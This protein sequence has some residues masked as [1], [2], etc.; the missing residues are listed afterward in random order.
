MG[1]Y[2]QD[3]H[4]H[5]G[6][7]ADSD[8]QMETV[9]KA[10]ILKGIDEIAFTDHLDFGPEDVGGPFPLGDYM[11]AIHRCR[12]RFGRELEIRAGIEVGEPHIYANE[13]AAVLS[14]GDFDLVLGSAHYAANMEPAWHEGF[15]KE[16]LSDAYASY[17][18]QVAGLAAEG[19]FDVLAHLDLVK[20]D[21]RRFGKVYD[22]PGPYAGLI[23]PALSTVIERG[24]GIELNT[25]PWRRG[26]SE[27]CPSLEILRWYREMGGEILILGSDAHVPQAVGSHFGPALEMV[28]AAGFRRLA[29]FKRRQIDWKE[30]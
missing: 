19:D 5:S 26:Q 18:R 11:D 14:N 15:F 16:P 30:I 13:A 22:G 29:T 9:C 10:A 25:S 8:A 2:P 6:F 7:S 23:R 24:K 3:Y 1:R 21:A 27:P 20:R 4:I 17:F 28:R 12:R